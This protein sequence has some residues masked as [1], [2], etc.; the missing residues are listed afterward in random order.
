VEQ[1]VATLRRWGVGPDSLVV[2]YDGGNGMVAA[3]LWWMLRWLGH[4]S[5]AVLNGGWQGWS[6]GGRPQS[7]AAPAPA[8]GTFRAGASRAHWVSTEEVALM[9]G[10]RRPTI[11]DARAAER[12]AGISE[13]ID[14]VAGHVPG[15]INHPATL[16]LDASGRFLAPAELRAQWLRTLGER[17]STDIVAMCGSGVSACQN[18]LAM[19]IAG[20]SGARLYP[21]SWSEWIR[22]RRRPIATGASD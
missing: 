3:R 2:A 6:A 17:A 19:E 20:L 13:P 7:T 16:N 14:P 5:V 15:A 8:A 10:Q 4:T 21:G 18:L 12:F 1:F 22:D 11:V 9:I